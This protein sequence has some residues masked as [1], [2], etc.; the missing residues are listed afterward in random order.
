MERGDICSVSLDPTQGHEQRGHRPVRVVSVSALNQSMGI[1]IVV[2]I[3]S[4]GQ[5]ARTAGFAVSL[6][7]AGTQTVGVV[8]CDQPRAMDL[9]A[10]AARRIKALPAPSLTRSWPGWRRSSGRPRCGQARRFCSGQARRQTAGC[11]PRHLGDHGRKS[12]RPQITTVYRGDRRPVLRRSSTVTTC[13]L[14]RHQGRAALGASPQ[15]S[16]RRNQLWNTP[17]S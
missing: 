12:R 1:A 7:G 13:L 11:S 2:P 4:G 9:R 15:V 17:R 6:M 14:V 5:H 16:V 3:T 8:R 10:R